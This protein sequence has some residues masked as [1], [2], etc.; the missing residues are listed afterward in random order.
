MTNNFNVLIYLKLLFLLLQYKSLFQNSQEIAK[1][2][3]VESK[4]NVR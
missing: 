1:E 2:F 3:F 4:E